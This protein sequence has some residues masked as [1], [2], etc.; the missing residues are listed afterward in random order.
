M[1]RIY[2]GIVI[3]LII[4]ICYWNNKNSKEDV[5]E[6]EPE[7]PFQ[8]IKYD[9]W[10]RKL[11]RN[12]AIIL[13]VVIGAISVFHELAW[14]GYL[15]PFGIEFHVSAWSSL[16]VGH[17]RLLVIGVWILYINCLLY[18]RRLRKH[19]YEIPERRQDYGY[20]LD[21][22]RRT[23]DVPNRTEGSSIISTVLAIICW[24]IAL[25]NFI[26]AFIFWDMHI[27]V[28]DIATVCM[29]GFGVIVLVW[30]FIGREYWKE[31]DCSKYRDDV[32]LDMNRRQRMHFFPGLVGVLIILA[33]SSSAI[34][35]MD[36]GADYVTAAREQAQEENRTG[37][38]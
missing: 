5:P 21:R 24:I 19:G 17:L 29:V 38:L 7:P 6:K 32:E 13:T 18:F 25:C 33:I 15:E 31:R 34:L 20:H 14:K 10:D 1:Y 28:K 12:A 23:T 3:L 36:F 2:E 16:V 22:L 26:G 27:V 8:K 9:N 37:E 11:Y 30:I 4:A 35:V